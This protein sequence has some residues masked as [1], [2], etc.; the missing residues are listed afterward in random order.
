M[1]SSKRRSGAGHILLSVLVLCTGLGLASTP[2]T[3][4][5]SEAETEPGKAA[6]AEQLAA[7]AQLGVATRA[8]TPETLRQSVVLL[9]A[10]TQLD[11]QEARFARLLAE[12]ALQAGDYDAAVEAYKNIYRIS[13]GSDRVA[14]MRLID[15]YTSR[16]ES[17]DARLKYL[18]PIADSDR[19]AAEVRSHAAY[20]AARLLLER[21]ENEEAHRR[22]DAALSFNPLNPQALKLKFELFGHTLTSAERAGLLLTMLKSNPAQPGVMASLAHELAEAGL[23]EQ[24]MQWYAASFNLAQSVARPI[25]PSD[26]VGYAAQLII[27]DQ[28]SLAEQV[29]TKL[30]EADASNVDAALLGLIVARRGGDAEKLAAAASAAESALLLRASQ[31]HSAKGR[32]TY[33]PVSASRAKPTTNACGNSRAAT[34]PSPRLRTASS[35]R[36]TPLLARNSNHRS[37]TCEYGPGIGPRAARRAARDAWTAARASAGSSSTA[38]IVIGTPALCRCA[39]DCP[40]QRRSDVVIRSNFRRSAG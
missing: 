13:N 32:Q 7:L 31:I 35:T 29:V 25:S 37:S 4:A 6:L 10:A 3:A 14:Q 2:L 30:L 39:Q 24:A 9:Q 27:S 40:A 11:P 18:N 36:V 12:A 26:M 8:I 23:H 5:A 17:A 34:R 28:T 20:L 19:V 38:T 1:L 21:A 15:L 22:L 33:S 16:M